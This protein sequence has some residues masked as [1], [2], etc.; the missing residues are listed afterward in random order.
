[1]TKVGSA[2]QPRNLGWIRNL[3][4]NALILRASLAGVTALVAGVLHVPS[5]SPLNLSFE[6]ASTTGTNGEVFFTSERSAYTQDQSKQFP[7]VADGSWHAYRITLPPKQV[8]DSVR[9]DPGNGKGKVAIRLLGLEEDGDVQRLHGATLV[10]ALGLMHDM[11]VQS[12]QTELTLISAGGDPYF[13]VKLPRRMGTTGDAMGPADLAALGI[14]ALLSWLLLELLATRLSGLLRLPRPMLRM[15]QRI[16]TIVSD[17]LVLRFDTPMILVFTAIACSA[18]LYVALGLNQTSLGIWET[19]YPAHPV[20]QS[21][22]LGTA[23]RI[24]SDEWMVQTPWVLNQV[25]NGSPVSNPNVGGESAPLLSSMPVGDAIALPQLKYAGFHFLGLDRGVSWSWAYKSFALAWSFLWL[26]LVL[27]RGNLPASLLGAGWIYF[28]SYTQWWFSSNLPEIMIAF[29]LGV[30]GAIYALRSVRRTHVAMGCVLIFYAAANLALNLYPPFIVPL[31]YLG[32]AILCGY[33]VANGY[34]GRSQHLHFRIVAI[35]A[36]TALVAAYGYT[37]IGMASDSIQAMLGTVYPGKRISASG[38]VSIVKGFYGFYEVFR[39]GELDLPMRPTN[40]SEASS[41][42][43]LWPMVLLLIP[44]RTLFHRENALLLACVSFC[45]VASLWM[46]LSMPSYLQWLMQKAGWSLVTP[47]RTIMALGV[48]SVLACTVL[49]SSMQERNDG[50]KG[51]TGGRILALVA[52]FIGVLVL[53]WKLHQIDQ[54]FFSWKIL[55]IGTGAAGLAAAGIALGR[56]CFLVAGL[57][58]YALP[59]FGINPLVSGIS[60]ISQKPILMAAASHGKQHDDKWLAVGDKYFAQGLKAHGLNVFGGAQFL[61]DRRSLSVLDPSGRYQDIWNRYAIVQVISNPHSHAAAFRKTRGD[62]YS[63]TLNVCG[64]ELRR[65]GITHVAYTVQVP[66]EDLAC[67]ARLP[68][69]EDS[70]V[71][72]FRLRH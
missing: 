24:R 51:I 6:M 5:Q 68:A 72:L 59:T 1:M 66:A 45:I 38:G 23:K 3:S 44:V 25:L 27:T 47:K 71:S 30:T 35:A 40:A 46:L 49:F 39:S 29:A 16:S 60:S 17:D 63:I 67:L 62:Q 22:D 52:A 32:I 11:Q 31:A 37:F 7:I 43:L 65:I 42:V 21:I 61:P 19:A 53:G 64:E 33:L 34:P 12:G 57:V 70:G 28:S 15:T 9:L 48:G 8:V 18:A 69:P 55:L 4:V 56:T 10:G 26:L 2:V 58:I 14:V 20:E 13:E 50:D 41:F 54:Q 36:T